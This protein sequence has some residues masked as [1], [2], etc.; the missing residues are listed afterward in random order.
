MFEGDAEFVPNLIVLLAA[1]SRPGGL[2]DA[3]RL[4]VRIRRLEHRRKPSDERTVGIHK[5]NVGIRS[6]EHTSE[7]QSPCN[8]VCRLL[9]EKKKKRARKQR[10]GMGA[11]DGC[12]E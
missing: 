6:E 2:R 5:F 12:D 3:Q 10:A 9:L 7:L 1:R 11:A 8:L 4:L